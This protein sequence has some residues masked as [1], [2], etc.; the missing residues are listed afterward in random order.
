M[1]KVFCRIKLKTMSALGNWRQNESLA[2]SLWAKTVQLISWPPAQQW[3]TG[4]GKENTKNRKTL[5]KSW[6]L[7]SGQYPPTSLITKKSKLC[8]EHQKKWAQKIKTNCDKHRLW[9]H[10]LGKKTAEKV[11][12]SCCPFRNPWLSFLVR[13]CQQQFQQWFVAHCVALFEWKRSI[14]ETIQP[15]KRNFSIKWTNKNLMKDK[16]ELS[17]GKPG[18][19]LLPH[20]C[21]FEKI[22]QYILFLLLLQTHY[23][24]IFHLS[25]KCFLILASQR[26][27]E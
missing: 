23:Q 20:C 17:A 1:I 4:G 27:S 25:P 8:V 13:V 11:F 15:P 10:C 14:S 18:S 21:T 19:D 5:E 3:N 6:T 16:Y 12:W 2:I 22:R 9:Y 24:Q 26:R 7:S